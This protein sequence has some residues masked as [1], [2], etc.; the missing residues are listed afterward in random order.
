MI[1]GK[2]HYEVSVGSDRKFG[3]TFAVVFA[4]IGLFPLVVGGRI[5]LW[6]LAIALLF[7]VVALLRPPL[8]HRLNI[9]WFKFGML[10]SRI[11][12]PIV[13][14]LIFFVAVVPIALVMRALGKD[15]LGRKFDRNATTYWVSRDATQA[16][17]SMKNQ[18]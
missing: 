18:F 6:A 7:L 15:M 2:A 17:A 13:T 14:G 12:S 8:L 5:R 4:L 10:L 9:F 16:A 3:I 11:V 1:D